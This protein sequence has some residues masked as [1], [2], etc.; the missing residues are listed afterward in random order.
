MF[1]RVVKINRRICAASRLVRD[2][3]D[4]LC[5]RE[6]GLA[7]V[8][9]SCYHSLETWCKMHLSSSG[10]LPILYLLISCIFLA[11]G[12]AP[13][14]DYKIAVAVS[15]KNRLA[16]SPPVRGVNIHLFR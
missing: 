12:S 2:V 13:T 9:S 5:V 4:L 3:R 1:G 14:C 7:V 16:F 15:T 6:V 10:V 11:F 8:S